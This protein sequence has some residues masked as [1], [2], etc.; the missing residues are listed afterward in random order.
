MKKRLLALLLVS[1]MALSMA[2][3]GSKETEKPEETTEDVTEEAA[4]EEMDLSA[5]G[6]STLTTLG[7]YK[8]LS[9][10]PMDTT[11]TDEDVEKEVQYLLD[12]SIK[13]EPQ[14]VATETSIVNID[15]AGKKDG[16]A[17]DRGTAQGTELDLANSHFIPGFAESIVGMKVGETK[18]CPMTFPEDYATAELAGADVVF[19]ITVNECWE[20]VPA[21]LNDE[22][23]QSQ[24]YDTVDAMYAGIR[25][26]YEEAKAQEAK[27][28][29][30][31][32]LL[33]KVID[34][35][36]FEL[37][38]DEIAIYVSDFVSQYE[39]YAAYYGYSLE[40]YAI[41]A[42]G[43]TMDQ[44]EEQARE[45]AIYRIQCPLIQRAVADAEGLEITEE[46]YAEK[47]AGYVEYYGLAS[48]EELEEKYTKET[49]VFDYYFL[50]GVFYAVETKK[51]F[52]NNINCFVLYCYVNLCVY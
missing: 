43:L 45:I 34:N 13:K 14:E 51:D 20:N 31:Y 4:A 9:Y 52:Y 11:V 35:S 27:A 19:T 6:S 12:A 7:E 42:L 49:E 5:L 17:F 38:E 8:G 24:G 26:M 3:C 40:N 36:T 10:V 33:Q 28:D 50:I 1:C 25:E 2:A 22:F 41:L 18:D 16:V 30:E 48:V 21:E 39:T 29:R 47:A 15:Y 32:Q 37:N 23:A 44:F 46:T